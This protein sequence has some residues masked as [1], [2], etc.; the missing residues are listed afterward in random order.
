[1]FEFGCFYCDC[2]ENNE[3]CVDIL[4]QFNEC[5]LGYIY[6]LDSWYYFYLVYIDLKNQSKVQEYCDKILQKYFIFIYG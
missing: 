5:F 1:M 4:E 2:L 3:K 6:E